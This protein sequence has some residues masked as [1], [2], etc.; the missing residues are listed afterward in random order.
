MMDPCCGGGRP[1]HEDRDSLRKRVEWLDQTR[2]DHR[3]IPIPI[4]KLL[5]CAK[6]TPA[7]IFRHLRNRSRPSTIHGAP[8]L[9]VPENHPAGPHQ[10]TVALRC[11]KGRAL[12][13]GQLRNCELISLFVNPVT[14][15]MVCG[16]G[17]HTL[18]RDQTTSWYTYP[19]MQ[20]L[21]RKYS[22][23][24]GA[25]QQVGPLGWVWGRGWGSYM[26]SPPERAAK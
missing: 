10:P 18:N 9:S 17:I 8:A 26:V 12:S 15:S 14:S 2:T 1:S 5:H 6:P 3:S 24:R 4:S 16:H 22:G 19:N 13:I 11:K 7:T 25:T 21:C 20:A 23:Q